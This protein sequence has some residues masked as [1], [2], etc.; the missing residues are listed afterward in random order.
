MI[1]VSF[2]LRF[3]RSSLRKIYIPPRS[4]YAPLV[5]VLSLLA[6]LTFRSCRKYL[7]TSEMS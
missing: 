4:A 2:I 5:G 1:K 3:A 7:I 6:P